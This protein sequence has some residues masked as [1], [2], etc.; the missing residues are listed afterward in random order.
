MAS[1]LYIEEYKAQGEAQLSPWS[2]PTHNTSNWPFPYG[3]CFWAMADAVFWVLSVMEGPSCVRRLACTGFGC[4]FDPTSY[5]AK[6]QILRE[7]QDHCRRHG[8][9]LPSHPRC[10]KPTEVKWTT[11]C[12]TYTSGNTATC[13]E[14]VEGSS[15]PASITQYEML[16]TATCIT[17]QEGISQQDSWL[18]NMDTNMLWPKLQL[19]LTLCHMYSVQAE[20]IL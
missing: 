16:C 6:A 12:N 17:L 19:L 11:T 7:D 4:H 1:G 14:E 5:Q 15:S 9:F 3:E 13:K 2:A 8:Q 18:W 20:E 10:C